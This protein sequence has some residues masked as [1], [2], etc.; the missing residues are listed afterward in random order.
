MSA[1]GRRHRVADDGG[2]RMDE[3]RR[4]H[5]H[6]DEERQHARDDRDDVRGDRA[7]VHEEAVSDRRGGESEEHQRHP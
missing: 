5:R 3:A 4:D 1:A 6:T 7:S 2:K